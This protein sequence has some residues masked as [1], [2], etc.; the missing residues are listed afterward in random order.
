MAEGRDCANA[1]LR[2]ED[3]AELP[4]AAGVDGLPATTAVRHAPA[5]AL[6]RQCVVLS[7]WTT[8]RRSHSHHPGLRRVGPSGTEAT[9]WLYYDEAR[10]NITERRGGKTTSGRSEMRSEIGIERKILPC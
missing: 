9:G 5:C 8:V 2:P 3:G 6:S 10:E 1:Q 4:G 7:G